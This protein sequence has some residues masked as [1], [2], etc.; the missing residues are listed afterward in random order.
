MKILFAADTM[1]YSEY[2]LQEL[3]NL[4]E[5]T[6]AGI[7]IVGVAKSSPSRE[8]HSGIHDSVKLDDP[9]ME[10]LDRYRERFLNHWKEGESPYEARDCKYEWLTLRSNVWE[11]I[12][13]CRGNIK[14]LNV[15][16]RFGNVVKEIL[17][18]SE[19][20]RCDLIIL[21]C[22]KGSQCLWEEVPNVPEKVVN[23]AEC[24]VFL[25]K[26]AHPI[27]KIY[28]CLDETNIT[29]ES[30]E[31][32]NQMASIHG[33]EIELIGLTKGMGIK[34][35]VYPWLEKV[36]EYLEGKGLDV[37]LNYR[38]ISDFEPFLK[39]E[40]R[41]GLLALWMGKKSLLDRFFSKSSIG[42]FI[43]TCPTS[44]LVLR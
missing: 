32:I 38:E 22:T 4:A 36:F 33:A 10:A 28:A 39:S 35:D 12:K 17:A 2:A 31:M 30:L 27:N 16:V 14:D 34:A 37:S 15:R 3:I 5:N 18:E 21:G 42:R 44:V 11:Q 25:V 24:S 41:E 7:T 20:S 26:E 29:Q 40:V 9:L 8:I 6:F 1:P 13:V 43:K 19:E 23:E